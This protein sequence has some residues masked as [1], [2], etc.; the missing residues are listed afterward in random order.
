M[1][2]AVVYTLLATATLFFFI[3]RSPTNIEGKKGDLNRRFGYKILERAPIFDP[4]VTK[5]EREAEQKKQQ[6]NNDYFND[7]DK[8]VSRRTSLENTTSVNEVAEK[9]QYLTSGGELN[10]TL[11]LFILFPLL[12]RE[13][14]D[15]FVDFDELESWIIQRANERLDYATQVELDS[16]DI[17]GDL[18]ISFKECLPHLSQN[19]IGD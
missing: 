19:D 7:N 12:D 3:V 14:K 18:A 15:G 11:R 16:K 13:P 9:Y 10:T 6:K 4:I 8:V 17:N 2:K 1:S 5:I